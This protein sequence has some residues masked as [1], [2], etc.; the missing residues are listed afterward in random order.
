MQTALSRIWTWVNSI[1]DNDS[2]YGKCYKNGKAYWPDMFISWSLIWKFH[3]IIFIWNFHS[4]IFNLINTIKNTPKLKYTHTLTL[5][6]IC[7]YIY[8]Q[9][10]THIHIYIHTYKY[11]HTQIY[12]HIY[13]H[14]QIFIKFSRFGLVWFYGTSTIVGYL[15][16]KSIFIHMNNY[17]TKKSVY[18]EYNFLFILS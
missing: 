5:T 14:T 12:V 3:C 10:Y 6:Y 7:A 13:A 17:I 2:H 1:S 16:P 11:I 9:I 18:Y 4:I 15:V 8:V